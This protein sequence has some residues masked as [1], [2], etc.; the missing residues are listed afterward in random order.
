MGLA[1]GEPKRFFFTTTARPAVAPYLSA[2]RALNPRYD[3]E[4]D[5]PQ[6]RKLP[7]TPPPWVQPGSIFFITICCTPRDR[8]Q[9]CHPEVASRI[10]ETIAFRQE[11]RLWYVHI[12]LLMPDHVHALMSFSPEKAMQFTIAQWKEYVAKEV[13]IQWQRDFFD[14]RLRSSESSQAKAQY[15]R[16]NPVRKG[17]VADPKEWPY[18]WL[19]DR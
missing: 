7:H 13:G 2:G 17:L 11:Q 18:V 8:N 9:L 5:L 3:F 19:P 4:M 15:I 10:F 6:R 12:L 14:H 1:P 16:E